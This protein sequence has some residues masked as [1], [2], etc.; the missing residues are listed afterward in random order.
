MLLAIPLLWNTLPLSRFPKVSQTETILK[1]DWNEPVTLDENNRRVSA[2]LA[3]LKTKLIYSIEEAGRQQYLLSGNDESASSENKLILKTG[4]PGE[5]DQLI[6]ETTSSLQKKFPSAAFTFSE[7]ENIFNLAFGKKSPPL[8][9]K[10]SYDDPDGPQYLTG[11]NRVAR[12]I[13]TSLGEKATAQI[14]TRPLI[15]IESD[16]EKLLFY[17]V[18]SNE[19]SRVIKNAFNVNTVF[20]INDNNVFIPVTIGNTP[21]TVFEIIQNLSVRNGKG[22]EIP[23]QGLVTVSNTSGLKTIVAGQEGEYFPLS[24]DIKPKELKKTM[25]LVKSAVEGTGFDT[26]FEGAIQSDKEMIAELSVIILVSLL[27]L[28]FILAAQFESIWLPAIVLFEVPVDIFGA[29][30]MLKLFGSGINIMSGIGIVVMSGIIINDSILKIDTI[31]RLMKQDYSILHAIFE[32]G[33]RRLKPIIMTSLTT[34]LGLLPMLFQKG[35]GAELQKP[36]SLSLIGGMV[37][38]TLVSLYIIPILYYLFK[39]FIL[40]KPKRQ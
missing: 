40:L 10:L 25:A 3:S 31:N 22:E 18:S 4:T 20:N 29:L 38:G 35:L 19:L 15:L 28:Y 26:T 13:E 14:L 32:A 33:R 24:I 9:A 6:A 11:L 1:I 5:L 27:L 21:Q 16:P 8:V 39:R 12:K 23:L 37:V 34:V 7:S 2:M 17:D 30:F 36:L